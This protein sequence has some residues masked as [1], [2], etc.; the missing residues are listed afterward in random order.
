MYVGCYLL[1]TPSTS[2]LI[3]SILRSP[4]VSGCTI[5]YGWL[6][7]RYASFLLVFVCV[8]LVPPLR[9]LV[10]GWAD[11]RSRHALIAAVLLNGSSGH[12]SPVTN[13]SLRPRRHTTDIYQTNPPPSLKPHT[14]HPKASLTL[15]SLLLSPPPSSSLLSH[16]RP[17]SPPVSLSMAWHAWTDVC[18][19][20]ECAK[21]SECFVL[22]PLR[23]LR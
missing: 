19:R 22:G 2:L 4:C 9:V 21:P 14:P 1:T 12:C 16:S 11:D 20:C 6:C 13:S 8:C 23:L 3:P 15:S 7:C 17:P 5:V 10:D 18:G